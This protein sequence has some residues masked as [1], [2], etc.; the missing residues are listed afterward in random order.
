M[1]SRS[2]MPRLALPP[3][4]PPSS[5]TPPV[6]S[7]TP[8]AHDPA[9]RSAAAGRPAVR[10][11][12][13]PGAPLRRR[14][15]ALGQALLALVRLLLAWQ[16]RA[17]ERLRLREMDDHMLKD[18]GVSRAEALRESAKPFWRL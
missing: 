1:A 5:G 13:R 8:H 10:G 4:G 14:D 18:I 12:T 3:G 6:P 15:T 16:E 17:D 11:A 2:L 9:S 7:G